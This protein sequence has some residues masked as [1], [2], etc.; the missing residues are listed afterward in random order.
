M[1]SRPTPS[2]G[3]NDESQHIA[4]E[5]RRPGRWKGEKSALCLSS[6]NAN[7]EGIVSNTEDLMRNV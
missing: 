5:D 6:R 1:V 4:G 2:R 3:Q 7:A